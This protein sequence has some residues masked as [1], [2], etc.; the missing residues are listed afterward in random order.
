MEAGEEAAG[1]WRCAGQLARIR[2][3]SAVRPLAL[4]VLCARCARYARGSYCAV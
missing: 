4:A 3:R 1:V 2:A